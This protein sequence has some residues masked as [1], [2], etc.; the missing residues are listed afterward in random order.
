[1][2]NDHWLSRLTEFPATEMEEDLVVGRWRVGELPLGPG[3]TE[4]FFS[5]TEQNSGEPPAV[6][7][8][9]PEGAHLSRIFQSVL[10]VVDFG[11]R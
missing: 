6:P 2:G 4:G 7:L 8:W 1:M 9:P 11:S 3:P 10:A 5:W